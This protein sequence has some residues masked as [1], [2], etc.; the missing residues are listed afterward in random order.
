[1]THTNRKFTGSA[2]TTAIILAILCIAIAVLNIIMEKDGEVL[3]KSTSSTIVLI[4]GILCAMLFGMIARWMHS[5]YTKCP[6][7]KVPNA[8]KRTS[9]E[10]VSRRDTTIVNKINGEIR[11]TPALETIYHIHRKCKYCGQDDY[12]EK[13][14][15][16]K[17]GNF[18]H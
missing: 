12:L 11:H 4:I 16:Q 5:L 13:I 14:S 3:I 7:C 15:T 2:Q 17:K 10:I 18:A 9:K 6:H 1:M 8:M